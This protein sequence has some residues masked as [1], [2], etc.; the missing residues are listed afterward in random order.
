[1]NTFMHKHNRKVVSAFSKVYTV[2]I[3]FLASEINLPAQTP[4]FK[5]YT[6]SENYENLVTNVIFQDSVGFM[7]FGTS[8]GLFIFNGFDFKRY[9]LPG[10][11]NKNVVTA[12]YQAKNGDIWVGYQSGILA[13]YYQESLNPVNPEDTVL[14]KPIS[15]I[16]E[17]L[18]GKLWFSTYGNGLFRLENNHFIK[19]VEGNGFVSDDIYVM[20]MDKDGRIW[21]GSDY[22]LCICQ[23][24]NGNLESRH[25][26]LDDGLPDNIVRALYQD[27]QGNMWIG[28]YNHGVCR[29]DFNT[30]RL[31][32]S[33]TMKDWNYGPVNCIMGVGDGEMWIGTEYSG[34]VDYHFENKEYI[35]PMEKHHADMRVKILDIKVD[36]EGNAWVSDNFDGIHSANL[37]IE[38]LTLPDYLKDRNIQSILADDDNN[39]W[40]G[41]DDGLYQ[42]FLSGEQYGKIA[43]HLQSG[44]NKYNILSIYQDVNGYIWLGTFGSGVI[45]YFPGENHFTLMTEKDGLANNNVLSITG[46]GKDIWFATLGGVSRCTVQ[47]VIEK[48][49]PHFDNF[50]QQDGLGTNYIYRAFIDSQGDVWFATDGKGLTEY[51][52][53]KFTNYAEKQGLKSRIIYSLTEDHDG[54]IWLSSAKDGIYKFD[55][56]T[57][58]NYTRDNGLTNHNIS[59]LAVT[60][61]NEILIIHQNGIDIFDPKTETF[62]Y[63]SRETGIG[64]IDADLNALSTDDAGNIWMG[65]DNG[66]IKFASRNRRKIQQPEIHIND[67]F[68][69]LQ[70]LNDLKINKFTYDQNHISF[71]YIGLWFLSPQEVTYQHKLVGFDL[72]WITSKDQMAIYPNLAPGK[73][74]FEVR[75]G[76]R[77][78]FEHSSIVQY[79]FNIAPPFWKTQ[80]FIV[81]MVLVFITT[82]VALIKTREHRFKEWARL[83]REKISFQF[84]SLKSQINPHFLFNSF[85]T[86]ITVIEEDPQTATEYVEKMSD[87]FRSILAY[88]DLEVINLKEELI[89]LLDYFYLQKKRY[90][91]NFSLKIDVKNNVRNIRIPPLTLQMLAENAL[92]HNMVSKEHPLL[93]EVFQ[94]AD[95][96]YARNNVQLK[97]QS[98]PTTKYG[99]HNIVTRYQI[100][101]KEK[102]EVINDEKFFTVKMP[103]LNNG[104]KSTDHRR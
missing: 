23:Q 15:G 30:S 59:G 2:F 53:G 81:T 55:G 21:V 35:V 31:I 18:Q 16:V 44:P 45:R 26:S 88:R 70:P 87:F 95:Y 32:Y 41:T 89:L 60:S 78:N 6:L 8:E 98:E 69:Y 80:W 83:E 97:M 38:Q 74:T 77:N 24:R 66:I 20:T 82:L 48:D 52:N 72:D 7:Y 96:L 9:T 19:V 49:K 75:A 65:T 3:L 28:M 39:L 54:N 102:V 42:Y 63:Y 10:D 64:N 33:K 47:G 29:Y 1:M 22:G 91:E 36:R 71:S 5:N 27:Q 73:Y 104:N 93:F 14:Q 13:V 51:K 86:L 85:N 103:L 61:S 92:K 68:I 17:D 67:I 57:F 56:H 100:L 62:R 58:T 99:L 11:S 79:G 12:I 34:L 101:T 84:E 50:S 4:V 94:D 46:I 90:G 37:N 76:L 25:I 43:Q 40:F